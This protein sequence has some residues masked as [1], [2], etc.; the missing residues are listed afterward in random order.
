[1]TVYNVSIS[2]KTGSFTI[3]KRFLLLDC[4]IDNRIEFLKFLLETRL[5]SSVYQNNGDYLFYSIRNGNYNITKLLIEKKVDTGLNNALINSVIYNS[6]DIVKLLLEKG[7]DIHFN[8]DFALKWSLTKNYKDI[9]EL[10]LKN[11]ANKDI[12]EKY[13]QNKKEKKISNFLT[14]ALIGTAIGISTYKT[15]KLLKNYKDKIKKARQIKLKKVN[16]LKKETV[17]KL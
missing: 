5:F 15:H 14:Q 7:A 11:G 4:I 17:K 12:F 10:L 1:M 13:K 9:T 2:N 6:I 3:L 8:N 16:K